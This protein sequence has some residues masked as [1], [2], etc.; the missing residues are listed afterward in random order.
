M[1]IKEGRCFGALSVAAIQVGKPQRSWTMGL[2]SEQS[3]SL[4]VHR[5]YQALLLP[6]H[7][8]GMDII[9]STPSF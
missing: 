8:Y 4:T 2:P 9:L 3:S 6:A 7:V 1:S 5:V